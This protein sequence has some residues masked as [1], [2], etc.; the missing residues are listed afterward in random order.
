MGGNER[1][2]GKAYEKIDLPEVVKIMKDEERHEEEILNMLDEERLNYV[3][4]TVFGLNDALVELTGVLVGLTFA[5]QN[6]KIVGLPG[7]ITSMAEEQAE[8]TNPLRGSTVHGSCLHSY[9]CNTCEPLPRSRESFRGPG[10]H[11]DWSHS[12]CSF[13]HLLRFCGQGVQ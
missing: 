7:L 5:F 11:T 12:G 13:L 2:A 3:S 10:V 4:S 8:R 1:N 9:R 6:S